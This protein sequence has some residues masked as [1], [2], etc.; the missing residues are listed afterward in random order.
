MVH[1]SLATPQTAVVPALA[2]TRSGSILST[3]S[4]DLLAVSAAQPTI[5]ARSSNF[6][7]ACRKLTPIA[8][9]VYELE[10]VR[11]NLRR[12]IH[13]AESPAG[14]GDEKYDPES[15]SMT[16]DSRSDVEGGTG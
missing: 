1:G 15:A 3:S 11:C 14:V 13:T 10:R 9:T 5:S 16:G 8:I 4:A 2:A 6:L 7:H 12:E